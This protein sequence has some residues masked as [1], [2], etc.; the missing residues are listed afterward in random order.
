MKLQHIAPYLPYS[1]KCQTT[2]RGMVVITELNAIYSDNSYSF[3]NI[4]E[5]EKGFD[6]VKPLLKPMSA[7]NVSYI[8]ELAKIV[9]D[10]N[11]S[12]MEDAMA[13]IEKHK[14]TPE[15]MPYLLVKKLFEWNFDVFG[16]IDQGEAVQH[17]AD[18][19][20]Y[21]TACKRVLT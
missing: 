15:H 2:D 18:P 5:S 12:T 9:C 11:N 6:E 20:H 16:L 4:V 19:E 17:E 1:I 3:M 14:K 21:E 7:L 13:L 8:A 10:V